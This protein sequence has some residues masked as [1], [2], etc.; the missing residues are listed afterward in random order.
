MFL[1][2]HL[3]HSGMTETQD[4]PLFHLLSVEW[5]IPSA[6]VVSLLP[7]GEKSP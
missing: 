7:A 4:W 5:Q 3:V 1:V 2:A 6:T